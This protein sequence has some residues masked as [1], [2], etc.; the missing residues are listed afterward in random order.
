[1]TAPRFAG[2]R[3]YL[4]LGA[5]CLCLYVPGQAAI[6]V[7]DRDEARF[8]QAS[9]QMLETGDFLRIRFQDE[10]RNNKPAGIYWL[11]AAAV[12]AVSTARS[13]AIWPYRLPSL[14][15]AALAVLLTYGCGRALL[16]DA[17]GATIAAVLLAAALGTVAEAHIAKTDAALLAAVAAGQGALGL[18]YLRARAGSKAGPGVA[19]A[20]WVA[21]IASIALK[22]PIGPGLAAITAATLSFADRDA[23]WLRGLRPLAGLVAT[24][25]VATP[26][27]YAMQHATDGQFLAQSVGRDFWPKIIGAREAHG[28]PPLYYLALAFVTFWP[29]SL[30]L[31]PAMVA[32]WRRRRQP[33]TRFL[34]AWVVPAWVL[35]ELVPTKLPHYALPLYPALALLA[36]MSLT[37]S[38]GPRWARWLSG[39][40][41]LLATVALG[42][43]L[44]ALPI[45][46][47][48]GVAP[49]GI[50]GAGLLAGLTATLLYR[51][52]APSATA[53]LLAAMSLAFAV[54]AAQF[55]V[56]ALDRLWLSR[57]AAALVARHPPTGKPLTVIGYN[58]PSF[59]F[60]LDGKVRAGVA[61]TPVAAGDDAL[62]SNRAAAPFM[63]NLAAHGL[64]GRPLD[65]VR[66]L[67]Y[68]N[69]EQMT[70]TLYSIDAK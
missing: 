43:A 49:A 37:E 10:A 55:V 17:R 24:V 39:V 35:L 67:D 9:R 21:E 30:F 2:W 66:G 61:D 26:W 31:A 46:F 65:S 20:F 40:P 63:Q 27:L 11:Q 29:G 23:R 38:A 1:M 62:V 52:L 69:G 53:A 5:L 28:A 56:P 41:W 42:A 16:G 6:P 36:A 58:E 34:L 68:S 45:R 22:G 57:A 7:L 18:A 14:L 8:A 64:A 25:L 3:P 13:T 32:G 4:L 54:P 15:G 60:L 50:V 59:V 44:I 33:A 19:T 51:R 70:L 48:G 47:G 12:A